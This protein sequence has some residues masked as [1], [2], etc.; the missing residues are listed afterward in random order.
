[1]NI[2][3]W[4]EEISEVYFWYSERMR[5]ILGI[6]VKFEVYFGKFPLIKAIIFSKTTEYE[7]LRSAHLEYVYDIFVGTTT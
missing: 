2:P 7:F 3:K 1:M 4:T 6:S 5:C